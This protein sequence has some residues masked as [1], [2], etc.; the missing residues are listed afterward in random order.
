MSRCVPWRVHLGLTATALALLNRPGQFAAGQLDWMIDV[1]LKGQGQQPPRET[2]VVRV[3]VRVCVLRG[4]AGVRVR[5]CA[6][7]V[8]AGD[9]G[10][11]CPDGGRIDRRRGGEGMCPC[12]T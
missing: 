8:G 3:G 7:S 1:F 6:R 11:P 2:P 10:R 4:C 9:G 12:F 5:G